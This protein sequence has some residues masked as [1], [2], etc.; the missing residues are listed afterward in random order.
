M[1]D[2]R[3]LDASE[4]D[5]EAAV[6][7]ISREFRAGFEQV[8]RIDR[9]AATVFG[10][11]RSSP[12]DP[13]YQRARA[14]G[15]ALAAR[16]WATITGGGPGVMEGAN[17]GAREAGGLS[18]GFGIAL[19]REQRANPYLDL[20]YT[21]D[22]FYARK[23]CFVKPSEGFVVLPGGFGTLDELFE[24]LTLI[25]TEKV[26]HFPVVLIDSGYWSGLVHWVRTRLVSDRLIS[27]TDPEIIHVTNDPLEAVEI[28]VDGYE[29]RSAQ[30]SSSIAPRARS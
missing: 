1:D 24:A 11:A 25:Q 30:R 19:P 3:L 29:Q 9:P 20:S 23:V 13:S 28:L 22:H 2:R 8:S 26:P 18:V 12:E 6:D 16:G 15:H 4:T 10:S 7:K 17:R 21:F 27:P 14:V 5:T